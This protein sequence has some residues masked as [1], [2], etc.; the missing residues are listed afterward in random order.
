[1][2]PIVIY[3]ANC[4]DGFGAAWAI[5]KRHGDECDYHPG[6]YQ[7]PLP[8]C[9]GRDVIMVDFSY[10]R[11]AM[12]L[13]LAECASLTLLDHHESAMRD[14]EGLGEGLPRTKCDIQFDM[15]RSGA[16]M[17]WEHFHPG[18]DAPVLLHHIQDR[19][20]WR[21]SMPG[22]REVSA[23][24]FS[25]PYDF[26][27]WDLLMKQDPEHLMIEGAAIER[28]HHKDIDELVRVTMRR[29]PIGGFDVP[30]ASLPYTLSSDAGHLMAQGEPFAACYWDTAETRVF[31][32][33]S[34]EQGVNVAE[35]AAQYGGG[36]HRHA[37]GFSVARDHHLARM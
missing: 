37:A 11:P 27:L 8:D 14:L 5:W 9:S 24:L 22:T 32:L 28:K 36:G 25:Y 30:V 1:M 29:M 16:M 20:L 21:F 31:S 12:A 15:K 10:K 34:C 6:V 13:L 17:S 35:V 2:K 26:K 33:R 23:A 3:H 19:D 18:E 7:T 4:A